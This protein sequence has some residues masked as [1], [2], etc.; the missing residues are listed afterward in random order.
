MTF[1]ELYPWLAPFICHLIGGFCIQNHMTEKLRRKHWY[2]I[3]V[4]ALLYCIPFL[5]VYHLN[6]RLIILFLAQVLLSYCVT[7]YKELTYF[8]EHII[9]IGIAML[10]YLFHIY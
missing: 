1:K 9:S 6:H 7:K 2:M 3:V 5:I 8:R 4:H 10:L